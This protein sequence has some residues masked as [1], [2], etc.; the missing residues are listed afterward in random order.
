MEAGWV[1]EAAAPGRDV[2]ERRRY[3]RLTRAGREALKEEV[4][5]SARCSTSPARTA[6]SLGDREA[7]AMT[8]ARRSRA[9]SKAG[10]IGRRCR[11]VLAASAASTATRWRATSTRPAAR[12]R[13]R[14]DGA[15]WRLRCLMALDLVRTIAGRS[16][17]APACPPSARRAR[18]AR[19][20]RSPRLAVDARDADL[21]DSGRTA[22]TPRSSAWCSSR[23]IVR[24]ADRRDDR[25][26]SLG[27][28]A[29]AR[30]G[31]R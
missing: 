30:R 1:E 14:G 28:P 27:P 23:S 15:L 8:H 22:S 24:H 19:C 11:S 20:S 7:D 18:P 16:G 9:R 29:A 17:C 26:D 6:S 31:R 12:G 21:R 25:P 2:D 4:D 3:Y 10:C 13:G 5:G